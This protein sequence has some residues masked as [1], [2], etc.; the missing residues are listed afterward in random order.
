M[1][2]GETEATELDRG[3]RQ[4]KSGTAKSVRERA[5]IVSR[6]VKPLAELIRFVVA[7][8]GVVVADLK[9]TLPGRGAWVTATREAVTEAV[10]RKAFT[11]AFGKP[12]IDTGLVAQTEA[13]LERSALDALAMAGKAGRATSGFAKVEAALARDPVLALLHASDGA[14]D[15]LRKLESGIW[16][17]FGGEEGDESPVRTITSFSSAQL[18]LAL[19]R[20]SVVH[21]AVLAGP[22]GDAFLSRCARLDRFRAGNPGDG[23]NRKAS[24]RGVRS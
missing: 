23:R 9:A 22:A 1:H 7:P 10:R 8:D 21:A 13:L 6:T 19:G 16:R 15:G 17:R 20:A 12:V 24:A 5:C 14:A 3:P 2:A 18:D 4:T 11:R